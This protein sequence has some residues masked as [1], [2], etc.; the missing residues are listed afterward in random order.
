MKFGLDLENKEFV[1]DLI[2]LTI[3]YL[4]EFVGLVEIE[5]EIEI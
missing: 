4:Y 1:C 3:K 5:I 2:Y